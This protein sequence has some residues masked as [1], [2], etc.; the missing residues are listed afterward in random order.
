MREL[1]RCPQRNSS[2]LP[3]L[4]IIAAMNSRYTRPAHHKLARHDTH[5]R[6]MGL[7]A[8]S[9]RHLEALAKRQ[10]KRCPKLLT[11]RTNRDAGMTKI[12]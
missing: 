8:G 3:R 11:H 1:Q 2:V 7:L 4:A 10:Q 5:A 6:L 9:G 12:D